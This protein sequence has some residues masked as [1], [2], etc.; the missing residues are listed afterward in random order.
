[1]SSE[2]I[3]TA[4]R[5]MKRLPA[6]VKDWHVETGE[7]STGDPAVWVWVTLKD[8]VDWDV[9]QRLRTSVR[10]AVHRNLRRTEPWV[11]VRFRGADETDE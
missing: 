6:A 2:G 10:D 1:M 8:D 9:R 7:D 4:L 5:K 3:E 11:Y